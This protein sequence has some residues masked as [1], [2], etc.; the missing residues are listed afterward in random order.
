MATTI[1]TKNGSGAPTADDLSVGELA[2]DLTN[3]RLYS[4]NSSSEVIELGVNAAADTTFGDN[5]KA[6]FGDGSDLQ[7]YHD[8]SDSIINDNGTGS[9]KLQQG[10][11]TKLEVTTT[12]ID[13]T[14]TVTA[15]GLTVDGTTATIQDDSAN[16]RFENSAGTRTGYIQN[17]ADAFEI[18]N[19]QAT[20]MSFGTNNT[21]AMRITSAGQTQVV[22]YD[23]MTLGFPAIAGGASRSGIKPTV[24]GA[25]AGQLQFLVGGDNNT[26]A[27]TIAAMMDASGNVGIGTASPRSQLDVSDNDSTNGTKVIV[28][29]NSTDVSATNNASF[30]LYEL[31]TEYGRLQRARDGTGAVKLT[32]LSTQHLVLETL[33]AGN[34]YFRTN[35][36]EAMRI[37]SSGNLL[38]GTTDINPSQNAVEGIALSAGSY[39]GYFSAARSGGV[40]AQLARLTNDGDIL[41]FRNST[42]S[43]GSI[44]TTS[45]NVVIGT[46]N[47][48]L[49]FYDG[50]SAIIPHTAAGGAS[51]GLV[52]LGQGGFNE[53]RNLY[54]S[55]GVVFGDAGGTGTATSNSLDSYEEGTWTPAY[56]TTNSDATVAYQNQRGRYVKIGNFVSI[57]WYLEFGTV[58]SAGT[59]SV[60]VTG[61]PF[62]AET[63]NDSRGVDTFYNIDWDSATYNHPVSFLPSAA[64][65]ALQF[66][67]TRDSGAWAVASTTNMTVSTN[68]IISGSMTFR[69]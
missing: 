26:E 4:K 13:V 42:V 5:V 67:L 22:G 16:L 39:G 14:G 46:G 29:V 53:F 27:T 56:D 2:V 41:N 11:S 34:L 17:R 7:I 69:V 65:S 33:G 36:T 48:G 60:K 28:D 9:L 52:D 24:T 12:G 31:G 62:Q 50:G 47:T 59:G 37:D 15:D 21:E 44:G 43:V 64:T 54:L 38:V 51:N 10:G 25:G 63:D 30:S 49:R 20:F 32:A 45:S 61:V 3:K 58:T 66:L 68:D 35:D 6:I 18:W 8:A 1:I 23:A 19:D 55:G 40:V 57:T